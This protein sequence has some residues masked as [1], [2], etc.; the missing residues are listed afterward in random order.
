MNAT[1]PK[2]ATPLLRW[3]V[4]ALVVVVFVG[5]RQ[6]HPGGIWGI[7]RDAFSEKSSNPRTEQ[8]REKLLK[9]LLPIGASAMCM[10]RFGE[11]PDIAAAAAAYNA[12]NDI[13][14]KNLIAEIEA[15]G[16]LAASEKD[17]LDRK[18]YRAAAE[19][20]DDGQGARE[21]CKTLSDRI[22]AH[23]FDL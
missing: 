12:R 22:N 7:A 6:L 16:G 20:L 9:S 11:N 21:N 18:A 10:K 4:P 13:A 3:I 17:L 14:M 5:A 19:L 23:E 15:L 1:P 8:L 2:K